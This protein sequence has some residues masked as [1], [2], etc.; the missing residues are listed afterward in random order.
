MASGNF[1]SSTG[2]NLNLYI[3][4]SSTANIA[5]NY[6]DVVMTAYLRH[7]SLYVGAR[8]N[9]VLK[10]EGATANYD[11]PAISYGSS[12]IIDTQIG[13]KTI[14]VYH[15]QDGTMPSCDLYGSY[16]FNGTYG[17]QSISTITASKVVALDAIP[18]KSIAS[19]TA[20]VEVNGTNQ[21]TCTITRYDASFT[22]KVTFYIGDFAT[23][24]YKQ[25]YTGVGTSQA[26]AIPLAWMNAIPN[27]TSGQAKVRVETFSGATSLGYNEYTFD[28]TV[29]TTV[30]PVVTDI[31]FSK[32]SDAFS[33]GVYVKGIS[34][35]NVTGI[36]VTNQYS[37][38]TASFKGVAYPDT[39]TEQ[40]IATLLAIAADRTGAFELGPLSFIGAGKVAA[41]SKDT[42]TRVSARYS[43]N[44]TV[45]DYAPPSVTVTA[46]RCDAAGNPDPN[47]GYIKIRFQA[48]ISPVNNDNSKVYTLKFKR[49]IDSTWTTVDVSGLTGYTADQTYIRTA[50]AS[51]TWEVYGSAQDKVSTVSKTVQAST[52][53]VLMDFL[54]GG[55]GM[56]FGKVAETIDLFEFNKSAKFNQAVKMAGNAVQVSKSAAGILLIETD[57]TVKTSTEDIAKLADI[58]YD[59]DRLLTITVGSGKNYA[60]IQAAIDALPKNLGGSDVTIQID[61]GT[62]NED[63]VAADF[64]H[65][66][67]HIN[68]AAFSAGLATTKMKSLDLARCDVT[69]YL[70]QLGFTTPK[71]QGYATT[72]LSSLCIA[73]CRQVSCDYLDFT[74][75]S[76]DITS[77]SPTN[78]SLMRAEYGG[79]V[80]IGNS[81]FPASYR[82]IHARYD[83]GIYL[84]STN[85][86]GTVVS[87]GETCIVETGAR[88]TAS[89]TVSFF[90][91]A[92]THRYGGVAFFGDFMG[93]DISSAIAGNTVCDV[94]E[95]VAYYYPMLGIVNCSLKFTVKTGQSIGTGANN[96]I[97]TIPAAYA[98]GYSTPVA[99]FI[100]H[101][102]TRPMGF[103]SS[104]GNFNVRTNASIAAAA[105]LFFC[106]T[107]YTGVN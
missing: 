107:W 66:T 36:T 13:Q 1:I 2:V 105:T 103:V 86:F 78:S 71:V 17:G 34:K 87:G 21:A 27:A 33:A 31:A 72:A 11:A 43:E 96:A 24:S 23:T 80:Q 75:S 22:H 106:G 53:L 64:T 18:R 55:T 100:T 67:L 83:C 62:F 14:R 98:P 73:I 63:V 48:S 92:Y 8:S 97:G 47:G 76:A 84:L 101:D 7:S 77:G 37:A 32:V 30:I 52:A 79:T 26:Y 70:S 68:G 19:V 41:T 60:T 95:V 12:T 57:G 46:T 88:I 54:S 65:G 38:T 35:I 61:A 58:L 69:I 99:T 25:E 6:S 3:T 82:Y 45:Y 51:Y 9:Q 4:W 102:T 104:A 91:Q 16:Y 59:A 20:S 85:T 56:A 29:P 81:L 44:I 15:N 89:G 39:Y 90:S 28:I 40:D 5:G 74:E 50:S 94:S 49:T 42:R 93:V 10:A